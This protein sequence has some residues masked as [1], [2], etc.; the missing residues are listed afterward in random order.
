MTRFD[1]TYAVIVL[2]RKLAAPTKDDATA[3]T[4]IFRYLAG[5]VH[6]A[7]VFK[8]PT[9]LT[10]IVAYSDAN[11]ANDT[12]TYKGTTG[13]MITVDGNVICVQSKRQKC[14]ALSS[15]E[16]EYYSVGST[17][18]E[19]L[20]IELWRKKVSGINQVITVLCDNQSAMKL[21]SHDTIHQRS[22]HINIRYH[23]IRDHIAQGTVQI[24]WISTTHMLADILTKAMVT[25]QFTNL[26]NKILLC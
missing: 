4:R 15:T 24:E 9:K 7:L 8:T 11:Y 26:V 20:W 3:V 21:A 18:C 19:A 5:T 2:S 12:S 23:F 16:A 6:Y 10:G 14:V 1:I 13:T 25:T 22:K 17:V